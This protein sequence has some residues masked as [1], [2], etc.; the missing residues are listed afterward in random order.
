MGKIFGL[1]SPVVRF[2]TRVGELMIFT[3]LWILCCLPILTAGASSAALFRMMFNMKEDRSTKVT[4]FFRAFRDNFKKATVLWLILLAV[5]VALL[6]LFWLIALVESN[7][8][9]LVLMLV[10]S[11]MFF[12]TFIAAVYIFPLTA[13][14]E[15][16]VAGTVRN[17]LA[18]GLGH[19]RCSI[20]ACALLMLPLIA[21]EIFYE[22]FMSL[23]FLWTVLAPGAIAYGIVWILWPV[24]KKYIPEETKSGA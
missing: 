22:L 15:N 9:R 4:D 23:L 3:V 11:A 18:M 12:V 17:A 13:Y 1:D 8:I 6:V 10:F 19:L 5:A 2:M 14:F 7:L 24:F 16:T 20:P 21:R